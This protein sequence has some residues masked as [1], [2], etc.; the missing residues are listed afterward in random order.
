[1]KSLRNAVSHLACLALVASP[2]AGQVPVRGQPVRQAVEVAFAT[3]LQ[4][5][6][7]LDAQESE[8]VRGVLMEWGESRRELEQEERQVRRA[9]G[10][11]LRPGIAADADSVSRLIDRLLQNRVAYAE[12]FQGEMR[13]LEP[14]LTPAQRGQF[15]LL[16][17]QL[18][19][20]VR[21]LQA[22]REVPTRVLQERRNRP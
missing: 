19:Q 5:E 14:I 3:R 21:Q 6:L 15:L 1:M 16:R 7:G 22:D 13:A 9:L 8:R 20:R 10:Q 17:D 11:Q 4:Q 2:L 12:S 18:L